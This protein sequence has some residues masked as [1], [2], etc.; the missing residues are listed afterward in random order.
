MGTIGGS[1]G[2]H[3]VGTMGGSRGAHQVGTIGGVG[4]LIR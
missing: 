2:T 4:E 1:V 3:Q